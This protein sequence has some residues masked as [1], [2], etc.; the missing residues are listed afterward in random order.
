MFWQALIDDFMSRMQLHA[1]PVRIQLWNGHAVDL[2][3]EPPVV[4]RVKSLKGLRHVA[5]ASLDSLGQAYVEGHIDL[6]GK[7]LD[8]ID[9]ATQLACHSGQAERN[10]NAESSSHSRELDRSAIQYHYDVSNA[11]YAQWLDPQMVYSCAYFHTRDDTLEAAQRQKI[12]HILTKIR[13]QPG[14]TLLDIGC[15]WGALAIRAAS[16][17]GAKVLGVTL[18]ENQ[19]EFARER[20][21]RE[22]LADRCEVRLL[23]Y[24]DVSG[25]FDRITSVGMFEHVGLAN[26]ETYFRCIDEHLEDGGVVMNHGITSTDPW[27][28]S[29]PWGGGDFIDRYVFPHGELP[30]ISLVLQ[31]MSAAGL[32]AADVENLRHHYALTL[33]HWAARFE[34]AGDSIRTLAGEERYRIWR[35]YLAGCAHAFTHEWVALHQVLGIKRGGARPGYP[36]PLTRD[37]MYVH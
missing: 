3:P 11:F 19:Y 16:H 4:I 8:L 12:D 34:A 14:Q 28:R 25:K 2:A 32:E 23:D 35:I 5:R 26:L 1:I 9:V 37:Y 6:E 27:S 10:D 15:G 36:L 7:L 18:S 20:I 17:Y 24:R 22:G 33:Q 31:T 13:L 30:H 21:Q 29:S